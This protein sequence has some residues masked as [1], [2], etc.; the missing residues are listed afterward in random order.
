MSQETIRQRVSLQ[1][2]SDEIETKSDNISSTNE[3]DHNRSYKHACAIHLKNVP[4]VLS[5]EAPPESYRGFLN[6]AMLILAVSNIRLII[7]NYLKYGFLISTP[8]TFVP[9]EDY[10][11]FPISMLLFPI[12]LL[13]AYYIEKT[14]V[15]PFMTEI[16]TAKVEDREPKLNPKIQSINKR[17]AILHT[18]N[19]SVTLF[20][21]TIFSYFLIFH[22][23]LATFTLFI[24]VILFLKLL[25]YA[26][27][28]RDLR[29]SQL[30]GIFA[31]KDIVNLNLD[32]Y[33]VE[34]PKNIT[35]ANLVYF[36]FA[37]TLCY[38]PSYPRAPERF[39]PGFF[40]K[41]CGE[42]A[43]ACT[44]MYFLIEQYANPTLKNSIRAM[45]ELSLINIVERVL[46]LSTTS[47][48]IWLLMF[49]AFFHSFLNALAEVLRF[50]DRT[51][52]LAWW[53]SGSL[54]SY[55]RLWNRPVYQWF[56][57]HVYLPLFDL[58]ISP[59]IASLIVFTISAA[60]HELMVG[61]P[62]HA[63][64][65]YAFGGMMAQIPLIELT[66]PLEKWR[67]KGTTLGNVIFWVSFCVVGQPA[68]VLLYYYQWVITH[69]T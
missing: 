45:E 16:K 48:A 38:Q 7:E 18:I 20:Y 6:L 19:V 10:I 46:K 24:G 67:G 61:V 23:V 42:L 35:F 14:T 53:N 47:L 3:T 43:I 27:V 21:P 4:S 60:L 59:M 33:T 62:T 66:K 68:C 63:I 69:R 34:Y 12:N 65:G 26:L 29:L 11:F 30:T 36:W 39:R 55:W 56:K 25:S 54:N 64:M 31:S 28:N 52:Y 32:S 8:G 1:T 13:F 57:R 5:K 22:P 50:G 51:F 37:P 15:L 41:R 9:P 40:L 44:M 58:G 17:A 2:S 49:Y